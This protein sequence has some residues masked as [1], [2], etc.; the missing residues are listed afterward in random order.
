M[1]PQMYVVV[2]TNYA[3]QKVW[4]TGYGQA[5][6]LAQTEQILKGEGHIVDFVKDDENNVVYSGRAVK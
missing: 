6:I 4:A 5:I 2:F 3:V 1:R